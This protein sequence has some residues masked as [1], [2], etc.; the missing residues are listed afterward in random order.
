[1]F[2]G[3]SFVIF[4]LVFSSTFIFYLFVTLLIG[5]LECLGSFSNFLIFLVLDVFSLSSF[6]F[7]EISSTF[8][9]HSLLIFKISTIIFLISKGFFLFPEFYFL[10]SMLSL[11]YEKKYT[12]TYIYHTKDNNYRFFISFSHVLYI[13]LFY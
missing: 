8:Y 1:M 6:T 4:S 3:N 13:D 12:H 5:L 7:K 2:L 11:F 10:N 9:S